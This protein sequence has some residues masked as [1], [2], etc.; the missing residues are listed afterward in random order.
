VKKDPALPERVFPHGA[1]Y[2]IAVAKGGKREWH[3]LSRIKDGLPAVWAAYKTFVDVDVK[4]YRVPALIAEWR[5][6]VMV[7]FKEKTKKD[8]RAM[9][10]RIANALAEFEPDQVEPPDCVEFLKPWSAKARSFN[11]YRSLLR[12]LFRFAIEKGRRKAGTNPIDGIIKTKPEVPRTRYITDSQLRRIKIAHLYGEGKTKTGRPQR[13]RSGMTMACLIEIAY[14]TGQ[15]IGV[16]VR[17][18]KKVDPEQP[19]EPHVCDDGIF[20]RRDKVKHSTGAAVMVEWTPRLRAAVSRL[21]ALQAERALRKRASQRVETDHL[22]TKQAGTPLNYEAASNAWQR[23]I[24]RAQAL[25]K[26][27]PTMFRD[28]RAKALTD[29]EA[30][31]GIR[32]ANA[33][34]AHSTEAQT[35]D[36]V[37]R[38]SARRVGAVK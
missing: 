32:A 27:P 18:L 38:K 17:I 4:A 24:K 10:E 25:Y 29:K 8:Y 31:E 35:Q 2:R 12:E 20:F 3:N 1:W 23:G 6:E 21:L 13:T 16:L 30:R 37:R 19:D 15:D 11:A 9:T 28:I 7:R 34:G 14:L 5:D 36:Y 33:M 22:F 26:V